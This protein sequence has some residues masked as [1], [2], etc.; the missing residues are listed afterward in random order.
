MCDKN[1]STRVRSGELD[2]ELDEMIVVLKARKDYLLPSA[3]EFSIGDRVKIIS[4]RPK[5]LKGV[6]ATVT[7]VKRT[8]VVVDLDHPAGTY[9]KNCSAPAYT[10][11]KI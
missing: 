5:Y 10:L 9:H 6:K 7:E 1:F 4:A 11:Q 8:R 2:Q 3:N